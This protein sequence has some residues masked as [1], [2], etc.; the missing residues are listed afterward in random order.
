MGVPLDTIV[1]HSGQ[2][3]LQVGD[4]FYPMPG[5]SAYLLVLDRNTLAREAF[6]QL[7]LGVGIDT[8]L[9]DDLRPYISPDASYLAVLTGPRGAGLGSTVLPQGSPFSYVFPVVSGLDDIKTIGNNAYNGAK[10]VGLQLAPSA[11]HAIPGEL[12][13]Y[14]QRAGQG[15]LFSFVQT[16]AVPFTTR[17][18]LTTRVAPPPVAPSDGHS[19]LLVSALGTALDIAGSS[20]APRQPVVANGRTGLA[21]QRWLLVTGPDAPGQFEIQNANSGLCLDVFDG[22]RS[23]GATVVQ[24][25]CDHAFG[26]PAELWR[27][28]ARGDG[29]YLLTSAVSEL[30]LSVSGGSRAPGTPVVQDQYTAG[31]DGQGWSFEPIP[32]TTPV[33]PQGHGVYV[34]ASQVG[35]VLGT[36]RA[37]GAGSSSTGEEETDLPS[38]RWGLYPSPQAPQDFQ[39]VNLNSG[40]CLDVTGASTEQGAPV[41]QWP[42]DSGHEQPNQLWLPAVRPDGTYGLRSLSSGMVLTIPANSPTSGTPLVQA[43]DTGA[44]GQQWVFLPMAGDPEDL[45]VYALGSA[46][47]PAVDVQGGSRDTDAPLVS[48]NE[49]DAAS[50]QWRLEPSNNPAYRGYYGLVDVQSGQ[51]MQAEGGTAG[52]HK[53]LVQHPC[54]LDFGDTAQ[55]WHPARQPNGAYALQSAQV[56][57]LVVSLNGGATDPGTP[58][59]ESPNEGLKSQEWLLRPLART[60]TMSVGARDISARFPLGWAGFGVLA[61]DAALRPVFPDFPL[62]PY[63]TS[64]GTQI[65]DHVGQDGLAAELGA[66]AKLPG[67][68][69]MVQSVGAPHPTTE[70]WGRIGQAL[71]SLGGND[72]VFDHL[73]GSGGYALV[74]C[75]S[76]A[77]GQ[78]ETIG[79]TGADQLGGVLTRGF[80]ASF[81]ASM[82]DAQSS[83]GFSLLSVA[84]QPASAWPVP[85][86][87]GQAKAF[88]WV[89]QHLNLGNPN[90]SDPGGYCYRPASWNLRAEYCNTLISW[91]HKRADL[92]ALAPPGDAGFT[93]ADYEAVRSELNLEFEWVSQVRNLIDNLQK[94][95]VNSE[96][97][98]GFDVSKISSDV[99]NAAGGNGD[100]T[101]DVDGLDLTARLIDAAS[102]FAPEPLERVMGLVASG[103]SIASLVSEQPNGSQTLGKIS[104]KAAELGTQL[105]DRYA[106]AQD[107]L[108]F[109][110]NL[111]V[112][113]YA[114]LLTSNLQVEGGAWQMGYPLSSDM[115][116]ALSLGSRQWLWTEL[117]PTAYDQYRFSPPP[118]NGLTNVGC[119]ESVNGQVDYYYPFY[120]EPENAQFKPITGFDSSGQAQT[121]QVWALGKGDPWNDLTH[122]KVPPSSLG[123]YLFARPPRG[124]G[125]S[126]TVF[127]TSAP[128]TVMH[129][130][131]GLPS[132]CKWR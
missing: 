12:F 80:D 97:A 118:G 74:G 96:V 39:M 63:Y 93:I 42:C 6:S 16:D 127:F 117:L 122:F 29:T 2:R 52:D 45:G 95:F 21:S 57:G 128:F 120:D 129:H 23:P 70:G 58:I 81:R 69:V 108:G 61:L 1:D 100:A 110:F 92:N 90:A 4:T 3:T 104:T 24:W 9:T 55:L 66:L 82:A 130:E 126:P 34:V 105:R 77:N 60:L 107:K 53:P 19:Y 124:A 71:A 116:N 47:G 119:I 83:T 123:D 64:T 41:Q 115:V 13:G 131:D 40:M 25:T 109:V 49:T 50:Q 102:S 106:S 8:A 98:G 75:S 94:V 56:K 22:A 44:S 103:M 5:G 17:T 54:S 79:T 51:C 28:I 18:E 84:N 15:H 43:S 32:G 112:T 65:W 10:N 38:Q 73:D 76:C 30:A 101:V 36:G 91:S 46:L 33:A 89:S 125:L 121:S 132:N 114:K 31:A 37:T 86:S 85:A 11:A 26:D 72:Q 113:D 35:T 67:T 111:L 7:P 87:D 88:A 27:P 20:T 99:L 62:I 48:G 78:P 14:L 68:T 59:V